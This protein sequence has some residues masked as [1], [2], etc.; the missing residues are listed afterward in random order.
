MEQ[1]PSLNY[2]KIARLTGLSSV[3]VR[4]YMIEF[5]EERIFGA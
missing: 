2:S 5:E 4:N 3:T 1:D